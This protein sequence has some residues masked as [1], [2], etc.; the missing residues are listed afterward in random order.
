VDACEHAVAA[1]ALVDGLGAGAAAG[2]ALFDADLR[3]RLASPSIRT[4]ADAPPAPLAAALERARRDA[5]ATPAVQVRDD[6]GR[7]WRA[8]VRPLAGG[9]ALAALDVTGSDD[10]GARRRESEELLDAAQEMARVGWWSWHVGTGVVRMSPHLTAMVD[11]EPAGANEVSADLWRAS[12]I[13]EERAAAADAVGRAMRD[14][15]Q[16]DI[17]LRVRGGDGR[18]RVLHARAEPLRDDDGITVGLHGFSQDVTE[19]ES[20]TRQQRAVAEL[21]RAALA[22]ESVE[23]LLERAAALVGRTLLV[24]MAAVFELEPDGETLAMR[25]GWSV[26]PYTGPAHTMAGTDSQAGYCVATRAPVVV[27]EWEREDRFRRSASVAAVGARSGA[28]APIRGRGERPFGVVG[29]QSRTPDRFGPDAV[30][31]LQAVADV[32]ADAIDRARSAEEIA[33]LA[34]ARGRLVGQALEGEERARAAVAERLHDGVLQ[35]LLAAGHDLYGLDPDGG[36]PEV[37]A[38]QDRLRAIVASLREAMSALHPT[39]LRHGGLEAALAAVAEQQG[40]ARVHVHPAAAGRR[41]ELVLSLARELLANAGRHADPVHLSVTPAAGGVRLD[42][43]GR[44][45]DIA[46]V[47][48]RVEAVGGRVERADGVVAV[49][50]PRAP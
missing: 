43:A 26:A 30:V 11:L 37:R 49:L 48:E 29:A 4:W 6:G 8:D 39:V 41:D 19:E 14:G 31:F 1:T 32:L 46:G 36:R 3:L 24:D 25:A 27:A 7:V 10:A 45:G 34:A 21:G 20:A 47:A 16:L 33:E 42:V 5:R 23:R 12:V 44:G 13:P 28:C 35:E 18:P 15:T 9:V 40:N 17:R 38:V 22:G 2:F 50:L